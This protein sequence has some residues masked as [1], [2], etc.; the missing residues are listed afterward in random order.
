[1]LKELNLFQKPWINESVYFVV[2]LVFI[3][4]INQNATLAQELHASNTGP[5]YPGGKNAL[6]EFINKNLKYPDEAIKIGLSG[7]VEVKF[8]VDSEGKVGNIE[9]I[10]GISPGCDAEA[11]RLT[12]MLND[13]TPGIRQGKPINTFVCLLIEF[14]GDKKL[15]P[16]VIT[17]KIVEKTTGLPL[18]GILV[19]VRGTNIGTVSGPDGSYS[20]EVPSSADYLEYFGTGYSLKEVE[21][22]FHST[23]N[24]ELD[25]EYIIID[26]K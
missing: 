16:P 20:L 1:M 7:V 9:V 24:I 18:D 3:F 14:K 6:K 13:W 23:I 12:G 2:S 11:I 5:A 25:P 15:H 10:K 26:L 17:G 22:D 21:I 19:V 4:V 8:M